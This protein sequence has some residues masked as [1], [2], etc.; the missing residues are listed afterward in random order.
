MTGLEIAKIAYNAYRH[1]M[2]TQ[3][4]LQS[5]M[6]ERY[7]PLT[8]RSWYAENGVPVEK[9]DCKDGEHEMSDGT[10]TGWNVCKKCG[11]M[12]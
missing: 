5:G 10:G 12:E 2:T 9:Q 7:A 4:F 3:A 11:Y 8:F 6:D 1:G